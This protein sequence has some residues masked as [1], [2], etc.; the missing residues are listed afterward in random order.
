MF[1]DFHARNLDIKR[2]NY[3]VITL[4]PKIKEANNVK[5]YRPICLLN[6]DFKGFTKALNNRIIPVAKKV[7]G[8]NQTGFM[9]GRNILEGVVILHEV[10]HELKSKKKSGLILK[11]DFEKAYDR[12]RW[13]FLEEVMIGKGFPS[14]WIKRVMQT[15]VDGK[16]CV[17]VNG[18]RSPYFKTFKGLRQ[19]HPL[20]P[21]LFNILADTLSAL[22]DKAVTKG[23]IIGV[24]PELIPGGVSHIQYA[25]DTVIM[26][27]RS[28][29][30]VVNL[31]ILLYCFEWLLGLK[32]NFHK[33]EVYAFGFSQEEK[34]EL[35]N[36]LNYRLGELPLRYLGIPISDSHLGLNAFE[37]VYNKMRKRLDL[38]KGK[39]LTSGGR[40]ILTN[41]CLTS[42][43]MYTMGFYRLPASG[44]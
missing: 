11:I 8:E 24:L 7:I 27:D 25:D 6:V 35:A 36:M 14:G 26:V 16:V 22:L 3:G 13:D 2:L 42:L 37:E 23:H 30:S 43:P 33:S 39:N 12:V 21:I 38:W 15:V 17:N 44:H 32:I 19:G 18:Q 5:Q 31:K 9:K 10:I 28:V 29:Q 40:L 34:E 20:S 41:S 4:V 1:L